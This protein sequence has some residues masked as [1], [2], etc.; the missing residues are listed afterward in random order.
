MP[1]APTSV[2]PDTCH[3]VDFV[4]QLLARMIITGHTARI[5]GGRIYVERVRP[6]TGPAACMRRYR[7]R[8]KQGLIL[9][10]QTTKP[11]RAIYKPSTPPQPRPAPNAF[12]PLTAE[13]MPGR[14]KGGIV[15]Q[16]LNLAALKR[17]QLLGYPDVHGLTREEALDAINAVRQAR[18]SRSL[19][20]IAKRECKIV[21]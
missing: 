6:T 19:A 8:L 14:S 18:R 10:R 16:Q 12:P 17:G 11:Q 4:A 2:S 1:D 7:E 9:P 21:A 13:D 15:A 20:V 5:E 3:S